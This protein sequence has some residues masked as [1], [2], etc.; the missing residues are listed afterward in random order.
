VTG[1]NTP[2]ISYVPNPAAN[3]DI[4]KMRAILRPRGHGNRAMRLKISGQL[5]P[6]AG[7][8]SLVMPPFKF[9]FVRSLAVGIGARMAMICLFALLAYRAFLQAW[10]LAFSFC[11]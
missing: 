5:C 9:S 7:R 1:L 10:L 3:T 11:S 8:D 4:G 6:V 2:R